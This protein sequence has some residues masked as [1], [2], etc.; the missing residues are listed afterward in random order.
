MSGVGRR[1]PPA[2]RTAR[3]VV[4]R[5]IVHAVR[6]TA[7]MTTRFAGFLR[8]RT[9]P[10]HELCIESG[11]AGFDLIE[12][13]E[14]VL[15]AEEYYGAEEVVTHAVEDRRHYLRAARSC[16]RSERPRRYWVDPRSGAQTGMR[17]ILQSLGLAHLLAWYGVTPIVWLTDAP[18]RRWR[19]QAEI[20]S[21]KDGAVFVLVNPAQ[22]DIQFA[23][24][25]LVGPMPPPIS[26]RTL[27]RLIKARHV[28]PM[29]RPPRIVFAGSMYEPRR[30]SMLRIQQLLRERGLILEIHARELGEPRVP[31]EAYWALLTGSDI[32]VTTSAPN[33]EPGSDPTTFPHL[34]YRYTEAL[35][36]GAALVAPVVPGSEHV[37]RPGVD[38]F[39]FHDEQ[40]AAQAVQELVDR[41]EKRRAIAS[42]G[43]SRA[44]SIV[45]EG[46]TW[47]CI[48]DEVEV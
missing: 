36:A 18:V 2:S 14:L 11:R 48:D 19:L 16:I 37:Y 3:L 29:V 15:S 8:R 28:S 30:A 26:S 43:H 13:K 23:H 1:T 9:S 21:A 7:S 6:V 46:Y 10:R 27:A 33:S 5:W 25:R 4:H 44:A 31:D 39:S 42:S 22:S 20:L 40:S 24:R 12:V 17:A 34:I 38:Y 35:L 47:R 32:I 41:P 45:R